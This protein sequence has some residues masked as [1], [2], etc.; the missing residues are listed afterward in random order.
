MSDAEK[1]EEGCL[2]H[3]S[4]VVV[5]TNDAE[6]C[7]VLKW[8]ERQGKSVSRWM[9]DHVFDANNQHFCLSLSGDVVGWQDRMDRA[10]YYKPFS[11]FLDEKYH[12][13]I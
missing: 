1:I 12:D 4:T 9:Y 3:G 7:Y 10:L 13:R 2:E 11:E 6:L 8:A 5:T